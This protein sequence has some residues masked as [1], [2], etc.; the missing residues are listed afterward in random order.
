MVSRSLIQ[1]KGAFSG[2]QS[3]RSD[4]AEGQRNHDQQADQRYSDRAD[5]FIEQD[6]QKPFQQIQNQY[7]QQGRN[8]SQE[9][10]P[11]SA[12]GHISQQIRRYH[13]AADD[14]GDGLIAFERPGRR[15]GNEYRKQGKDQRKGQRNQ[16][17]GRIP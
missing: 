4:N 11:L 13:Q 6:I 12:S 3:Y 5:L 9:C 17:K 14:H 8:D 2:E 7:S 10:D 1:E 16:L 15:P